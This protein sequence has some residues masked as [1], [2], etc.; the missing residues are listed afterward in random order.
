MRLFV[1]LEIPAI[2]RA[3]LA[4][5][6]ARLRAQTGR[7]VRWVEP[8]NIHLT[9]K[10]IGDTDAARLHDIQAALSSIR[11]PQ[12]VLVVFRGLG[13]VR[14]P[15]PRVFAVGAEPSADLRGL[16]AEVD[17]VLVPAGAPA[18]SRDFFPHLT[19]ARLKSSENA[20]LLRAE[21]R[22]ISAVEFGRGACS[23]FDLMESRLRP[24]GA[25]YTRVARFPFCPPAAGTSG[26]AA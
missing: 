14:H 4:E 2:V 7:S 11:R 16:A 17:R 24:S 26:A 18:E 19:L 9:L 8:G 6:S 13:D 12:P 21:S 25:E 5:L 15:L 10:F 3:A 1:A 22:K 23:E 20:A